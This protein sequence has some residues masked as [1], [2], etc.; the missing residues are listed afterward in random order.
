MTSK[1]L[2]EQ[3]RE[4]FRKPTKLKSMSE[5]MRQ[6]KADQ[7]TEEVVQRIYD[8]CQWENPVMDDLFIPVP[9]PREAAA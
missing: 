4:L 1:L 3:L 9:K 6:W 7:A 2:V 8:V 5:A